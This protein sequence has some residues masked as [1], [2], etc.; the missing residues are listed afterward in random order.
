MCEVLSVLR[1]WRMRR[2][3]ARAPVLSVQ[4]VDGTLV[5]V[6]GRVRALD[7]KMLAAPTTGTPCVAFAIRV[8][9]PSRGE[10]G[11]F[12]PNK[13]FECVELVPFAIECEGLGMVV[14]DCP[15]AVLDGFHVHRGKQ[16]HDVHWT[17]FVDARGLSPSSVGA[18]SAVETGATITVVG[19]SLRRRTAPGREAG[20]RD[21]STELCLVGDFDHP[22][23]LIA[24]RDAGT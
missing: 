17:D 15:F 19:T 14:V 21:A 4:T 16:M 13:P 6:T 3:L 7:G 20:F 1:T 5:K 22:V 23:V 2:R 10:P 24:V 11:G 9:E 18:E 8:F 12:E